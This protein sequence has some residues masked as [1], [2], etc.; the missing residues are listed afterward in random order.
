MKKILQQVGI[1]E[2]RNHRVDFE[3]CPHCE[4]RMDWQKWDKYACLLI[5]ESSFEKKGHV[6]VISEC[7]KC[8]EKSWIHESM[9]CINAHRQ[10]PFPK[11]WIVAIEQFAA[12]CKLK[13]LRDWAVGLCGR[14]SQLSCGKIDYG[15]WR[16]CSIGF[17]PVAT[18]CDSFMSIDR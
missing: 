12:A 1:V 9:D 2:M 6:T 8:F 7:P 15:T 5:L 10:F 11:K 4:F 3:G 13:A 18:E 16:E 17:G 14:C